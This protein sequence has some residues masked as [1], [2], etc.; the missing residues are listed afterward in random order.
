MTK[1]ELSTLI[2]DQ[3]KAYNENL[4]EPVDLATGDDSVLFDGGVFCEF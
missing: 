2:I 1:S 4:D 3:V